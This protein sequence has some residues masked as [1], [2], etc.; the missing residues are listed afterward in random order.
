MVVV[1]LLHVRGNGAR[2]PFASLRVRRLR[3]H[4]GGL[5]LMRSS[6]D[7]F[8]LVARGTL[9]PEEAAHIAME[10][11]KHGVWW[12]KLLAILVAPFR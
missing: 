3:L 4:V 12:R 8:D 10:R 5:V 7:L 11:R 1:G 9:T 6:L 2:W